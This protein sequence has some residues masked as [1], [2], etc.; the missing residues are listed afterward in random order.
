[1]PEDADGRPAHPTGSSR[2]TRQ[3]L[4][5][6][7][8]ARRSGNPLLLPRLRDLRPS[9]PGPGDWRSAVR[10]LTVRRRRLPVR[11]QN[12]RSDCGPTA[13]AIV[14]AH[15]GIDPDLASL[16]RQLDTSR[17]GVSARALLEAARG[18]GLTGRGVRLPADA[19]HRLATGSIL[20]WNFSHFVVLERVTAR[21]L[22]IVDPLFGRRRLTLAD[23]ADA[24]TGVAL[25][26]ERPL[27]APAGPRYTARHRLAQSPWRFLAFFVT[28]GR[29][30]SALIGASLLL[31]L[32]NLATP[33]AT[34]FVVEHA[35][36]GEEPPHLTAL[37]AL[38]GACVL[39]V[40]TLQ[41]LRGLTL[42]SMQALADKRVTLGVLSHLLSLPYEYFTRRT[43][44]D[45]GL[46][47]RTSTA[48]RQILTGS[49]VS[50]IVDGTMVLVYL[51][52]LLL[53]DLRFA[54]LAI[55]LA[56]LQVLVMVAFW[57]RQ[58]YLAADAVEQQALAESGLMEILDG[59]QTLKASGLEDIACERWSR[60]LVDEINARSRSRQNQAVGSAL[61]VTLQF[62]APLA[63]LLTG[64]A[65]IAA[66]ETTL[67]AVVGYTALAVGVF[68]PLA[69][70]IQNALQVAGLGAQLARLAD[71]LDHR[72]EDREHGPT[73][74]VD[75]SGTIEVRG[76]SFGYP[77]SPTPALTDIDLTV[78]AGSF[79]VVAGRSGSGKSTLASVLA[80]LQDP[81]AGEVLIDGV[82]I[83][84]LDRV[85]L[86]RSLSYVSQE[87]RI[88]AGTIW[89][90]IAYAAPSAGKEQVVAAA[91]AAR[92]HED[93]SRLP[94][95]YGTLL[96]PG[97]LGLSGGQRQ[98][99]ALARALLRDPKLLILDEATSALDPATEAEVFAGLAGS[100]RTLVVIAHRLSALRAADQV[101]TVESGR[102]HRPAAAP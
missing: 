41:L 47:V 37:T 56:L 90:N 86:R 82:P 77:G 14:L 6:H 27:T 39:A 4:N 40:G 25:E 64:C 24:F 58:R 63:V 19:L 53:A 28:G 50:A 13:L 100:G 49:T 44:G 91:R 55:G 57:R 65:L 74:D 21:H 83:S 102:I 93:I 101:I 42:V 66:D 87:S 96:G 35:V 51:S 62:L 92:I 34:A 36:V 43:P 17:N 11:Y 71:V 23:A 80:G 73:P 29:K 5:H 72:P 84:S 10:R 18:R 99:I 95:K 98:R 32:L 8:S 45:L 81:D 2:F 75:V 1:M 70:L 7:T 31:L 59:L 69:N 89:D 61:S 52:L 97:G 26:F 3:A 9:G 68:T 33:L 48:V 54:A 38:A 85:A 76:L 12:E 16:R 88:F 46:R 15:H 30:L 78:P 20:F 67:S 60:S 94:M 79:T 22:H